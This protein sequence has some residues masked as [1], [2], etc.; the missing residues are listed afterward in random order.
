[1]EECFELAK[2]EVGLADYEVCHYPAWYQHI[3]LFMLLAV[4]TVARHAIAPQHHQKHL[5]IPPLR[6]T[7]SLLELRRLLN[8]FV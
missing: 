1:V 8:R 7:L 5:Y 4:L 3:T 6:V 2:Q